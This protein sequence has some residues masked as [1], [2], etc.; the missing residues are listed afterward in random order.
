[1]EENQLIITPQTKIGELLKAY[2]QLEDVLVEVAPA[3]KK[4]RNPVL[5]KTVAQVTSL[6]QAA[7]V[8]GVPVAELVQRLRAAV[9][10]HEPVDIKKDLSTGDYPLEPPSW[11]D[12]NKIMGSLDARPM[13]ESGEHPIGRVFLEL[14]KLND[15]QIY[16]LITPFEP[17]P[18]IDKAKGKGLTVWVTTVG[19]AEH[20]TYFYRK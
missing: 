3:F 1:M 11:Y 2:P 16:E 20:H 7:R 4:L 10:Q 5:R 19:A 9:G 17:A 6:A 15:G 13:I 14:D 18:L 12:E 8:G